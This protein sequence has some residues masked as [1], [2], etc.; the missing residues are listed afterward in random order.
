MHM[1]VHDARRS[2][3][4]HTCFT[5]HNDSV[6]TVIHSTLARHGKFSTEISIPIG[7]TD[8]SVDTDI[9]MMLQS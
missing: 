4:V 7:N 8:I 6:L 3:K 9:S 2:A 1:S 5:C